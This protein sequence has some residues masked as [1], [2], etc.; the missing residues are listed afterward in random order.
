MYHSTRAVDADKSGGGL[1]VPV[2][3]ALCGSVLGRNSRGGTIIVG[4]ATLGGSV[5]IVP[6]AAR[7]AELAVE[8]GAST[9]LTPVAA[10][11]QLNELPDDIWTKV[12]IEFYRDPADAIFKALED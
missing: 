5:E 1:G 12:N 6:Q 11:R 2:L 3:A 8:K 7:L 9:I 4:S 10:R